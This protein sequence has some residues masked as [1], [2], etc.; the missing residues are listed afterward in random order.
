MLA[1]TLSVGL[2]TTNVLCNGD[3]T[4]TGNVTV[5]GGT[6]PYT[7]VWTD[8][9]GGAAN[10][11]LLPAGSYKVTVTDSGTL[12]KIITF[13]ITEPA[14]LAL[15]VDVANETVPAAADGKAYA[16]VSGGTAPYTFIWKDNLGFPIGQTTQ[17]ATALAVGTYQV[18]I[19]DANL[20]FIEDLAVNIA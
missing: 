1:T 5:G 3:A 15:T 11:A 9:V 8:D 14:T 17:T 19:L 20:C 7:I 4:G 10:P 2:T 13:T 16:D 18:A 6:A 12:A